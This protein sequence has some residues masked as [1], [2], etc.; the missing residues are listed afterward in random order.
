M[1][2][3]HS[4]R[5]HAKH[6]HAEYQGA[7]AVIDIETGEVYAGQLPAKIMKKVQNWRMLRLNEL[8]KNW[9]SSTRGLALNQIEGL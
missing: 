7:V 3:R 8:L 9:E 4:K 1:E 6:F 5:R 2:Y